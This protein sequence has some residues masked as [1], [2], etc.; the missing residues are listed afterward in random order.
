MERVIPVDW[1]NVVALHDAYW[2]W[3]KVLNDC[4]WSDRGA[5]LPE[6]LS[7]AIAC[8]CVAGGILKDAK[9]DIKYQKNK[10]GEVKGTRGS[11]G[12]SSFSPDSKFDRLFLVVADPDN[13]NVYEVYDT[14]LSTSELGAIKVNRTQTFAEQQA[15]GRRP[16]FS[17]HAWVTSKGLGPTWRV[18]VSQR[19]VVRLV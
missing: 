12:P 17:L 19:N 16:R 13:H 14:G 7:E 2:A 18:D 1:D 5:N 4:P 10:V 3:D 6:A 15:A 9:G 8:L 11:G